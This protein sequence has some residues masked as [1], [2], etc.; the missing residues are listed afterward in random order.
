M[1]LQLVQLSVSVVFVSPLDDVTGVSG[2]DFFASLPAVAL[3]AAAFLQREA[4]R[5]IVSNWGIKKLA[6]KVELNFN[7]P[8]TNCLHRKP[9]V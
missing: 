8:L 1:H 6:F 4:L 2:V 3:L 9:L 7:G 5:G